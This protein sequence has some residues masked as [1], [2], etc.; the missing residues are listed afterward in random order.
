MLSDNNQAVI[1][2]FISTSRYLDDLHYNDSPYF[3][4]M[5]RLIHISHRNTAK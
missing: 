1:K 3:D 5:V 4:Q 2:A